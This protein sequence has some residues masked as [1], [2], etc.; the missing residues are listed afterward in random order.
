MVE[1]HGAIIELAVKSSF[2]SVGQVA[3]SLNVN[4]RTLYNW[5]SKPRLSLE[6]INKIG[7]KLNYDFGSDIPNSPSYKKETPRPELRGLDIPE[8]SVDYK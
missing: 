1:H 7:I 5:F 4:R 8:E 6:I 2:F 3:V